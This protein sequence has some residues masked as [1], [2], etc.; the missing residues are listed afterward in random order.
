MKNKNLPRFL[1]F[2]ML[3]LVIAAVAVLI[4]IKSTQ[5]VIGNPVTSTATPLASVQDQP[6]P[7]ISPT[8]TADVSS[9]SNGAATATPGG[10]RPPV[11]PIELTPVR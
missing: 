4:W 7:G 10:I 11:V 8:L 6:N 1:I 5:R 2:V 3:I 9:S